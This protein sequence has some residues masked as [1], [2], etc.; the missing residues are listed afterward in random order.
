[1]V[2]FPTHDGQGTITHITVGGHSSD[3]SVL[4]GWFVETKKKLEFPQMGEPSG[5][6]FF[7]SF[8][9]DVKPSQRIASGVSGLPVAPTIGKAAAT[10]RKSARPVF[11]SCS[12]IRPSSKGMPKSRIT[13]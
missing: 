13:H 2:L 11:A 8:H 1:M 12:S 4:D 10:N 7:Y 3:F 5:D 9:A 6:A